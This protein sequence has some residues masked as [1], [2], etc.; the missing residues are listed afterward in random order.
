MQVEDSLS[1]TYD[2]QQQAE[3]VSN[4]IQGIYNTMQQ[5]LVQLVD[6][7]TYAETVQPIT[8]E[9]AE[10]AAELAS[11][12]TAIAEQHEGNFSDALETTDAAYQ[13]A[14]SV[15]DSADMAQML[16][17]DLSREADNLIGRYQ[18]ASGEV[19]AV[20]SSV[21]EVRTTLEDVRSE[22]EAAENSAALLRDDAVA[23]DDIVTE[24][25]LELDTARL[26]VD[27]T[28][29][30]LSEICEQVDALRQVVG[31]VSEV[32]SGSGT[33]PG[34]LEPEQEVGME[35][36]S[37]LGSGVEPEPYTIVEGVARLREGVE[38]VR[39]EVMECDG[40]VAMAEDVADRLEQ[41][42]ANIDRYRSPHSQG[43]FFFPITFPWGSRLEGLSECR[44]FS[45]PPLA[46]SCR[47][48]W[49][50]GVWPWKPY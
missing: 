40:V 17:G 20:S 25:Q 36:G 37:G 45:P 46:V 31:N 50:Q 42:A 38:G 18:N 9:Q 13:R 4:Y 22:L 23:I 27:E 21:E 7:T 39:G 48:V 19:E 6:S 35:P 5:G 12:V 11:N 33:D 49:R 47:V 32:V 44:H 8:A 14:R 29:T 1:L 41:E 15:A 30:E 26:V 16:S 43:F 28:E 2:L 24:A 10:L 3:D 34:L